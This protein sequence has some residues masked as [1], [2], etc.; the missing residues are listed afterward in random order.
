MHSRASLRS[1]FARTQTSPSSHLCFF[2]LDAYGWTDLLPLLRIAHGNEAPAD[3]QTRDDAKRGFDEAILERLV[4]LNAER[5]AEE[6][7]GLVR[8]LRPEFQNLAAQAAPLQ[9]EMDAKTDDTVI[10]VA[11][12]PRPWPKN[13]VEQVRAVA[14]T[15][16]A[17]RAPLSPAE[18]AARFIGRGPW[19]KRLPQLLEM[20]VAVGRAHEKQ[21]RY[22]ST[23]G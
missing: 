22:S 5:A 23:S 9:T 18:L 21:G 6:A 11:T 16:S 13:A 1:T 19:K 3:G 7:R 2:V 8:W 17:S 14:E 20:L 4:A 10:A 15:L 12:K